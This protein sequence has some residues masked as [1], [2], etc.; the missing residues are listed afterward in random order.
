M[1]N[2]LVPISHISPSPTLNPKLGDRLRNIVTQ[3]RQEG[4][5]QIQATSRILGAAAQIAENHDR[6]VDEVVEMVE[7]DLNQPS[8]PASSESYTVER[9][10]QQFA[11]L[12][13]A[14][15]HF[16]VKA[17][18]WANLADKLNEPVAKPPYKPQQPP[19]IDQRLVAIEAEIQAMRG[20]INRILNLL[21]HLVSTVK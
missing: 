3:L 17:S 2:D 10:K 19:A 4:D 15:A 11:K 9:L 14:K 1:S 20:D 8:P 5:V 12:N 13:D 21:E 18:S 16:G 7:E 6:L